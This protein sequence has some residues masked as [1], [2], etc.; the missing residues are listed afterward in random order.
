MTIPTTK[1]FTLV[2]KKKTRKGKKVPK[3]TTPPASPTPAVEEQPDQ[4]LFEC[5]SGACSY[6]GFVLRYTGKNPKFKYTCPWFRAHE[7]RVTSYSQATDLL[8]TQK[9]YAEVDVKNWQARKACEFLWTFDQSDRPA[10][11]AVVNGSYTRGIKEAGD[12]LLWKTH[13][14]LTPA[15]LKALQETHPSYWFVTGTTH[16][17]HPIAHINT[18]I[19]SRGLIARVVAAGG[20]WL[21]LHG[22]PAA[23]AKTNVRH[24]NVTIKTMVELCTPKDHIR[25][26][27]KWGN[28]EQ[29]ANV[30]QSSMRDVSLHP[31]EDKRTLIGGL[32]GAISI[33]TLYYYERKEIAAF[34]A[35]NKGRPLHALVHRF[36]G[37]DGTLCNGEMTFCRR[38]GTFG[39]RI[40]QTNKD[41]G[42][43]YEHPDNE[44]L[45]QGASSW[46]NETDG[47][48]W[49]ISAA[50]CDTYLVTLVYVA[51]PACRMDPLAELGKQ[52][53]HCQG[54]LSVVLP[55]DQSPT[56][57]PSVCRVTA[58]YMVSH[59]SGKART[60]AQFKDHLA[61]TK[62]AMKKNGSLEHRS[63]AQTA[64]YSFV[65]DME[66]EKE[67]LR[68][69][70]DLQGESREIARYL[71]TGTAI[72]EMG[73]M[74]K[75][76]TVAATMS[77][78][79]KLSSAFRMG[80][81]LAR[82]HG[83]SLE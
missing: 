14:Q 44:W 49:T 38:A 30:F 69:I 41:T 81:A 35:M 13:L 20:T 77:D 21:D 82:T 23:N 42:E 61:A 2:E 59:V 64:V 46:H 60:S 68:V 4:Y 74:S 67:V 28:W 19:A 33:H 48:G 5:P 3:P 66:E 24:P 10:S 71:G 36:V 47:F 16:H 62:R 58:K 40:T 50:G 32:S 76:L 1:P 25:A 29:D 31:T 6:K 56:Y 79:K 53:T 72:D 52:L 80:A 22:N 27:T 18:Q 63:V 11:L 83:D 57:F 51:P 12:R 70:G 78:G 9:Q 65:R 26:A 17:D 7:F 34:L 73:V 54:E 75:M 37:D 45:F 43:S 8:S 15:Q 55:T 39:D